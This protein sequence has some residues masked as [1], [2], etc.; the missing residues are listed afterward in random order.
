M[1]GKSTVPGRGRKPK[2]AARKLL[3]GNPGKRAINTN[4]PQFTPL[5]SAE[6]PEWFDEIA[7]RMWETIIHEL[8]GQRVLHVT[9]LH[10][11]VL[12]CSAF[13]NW[14]EAQQEVMRKGITVETEFGPKKNP[15]L[16]AAN[17]AMRQIAT[18]GSMLGLDPASRQRL[19]T[20]TSG[21]TNPFN[22]L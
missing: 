8:C 4:E 3:A 14:H 10:N 16:T 18:F 22:N 6:P 11:V 1:S 2:P 20:P 19:I 12:F 7:R 13:R 9:D 21:S 5:T 17:E 15:A